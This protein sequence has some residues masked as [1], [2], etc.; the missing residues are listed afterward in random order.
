MHLSSGWYPDP[1]QPGIERFWDGSEWAYERPV[2]VA[3]PA[4]STVGFELPSHQVVAQMGGVAAVD[5]TKK[6]KRAGIR[7]TFKALGRITELRST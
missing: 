4:Q 2:T 1:S 6:A 7:G 3:P 5:S